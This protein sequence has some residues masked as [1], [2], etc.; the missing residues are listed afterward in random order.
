MITAGIMKHL[1]RYSNRSCAAEHFRQ[2]IYQKPV[3]TPQ[4]L[5]LTCGLCGWGCAEPLCTTCSRCVLRCSPLQPTKRPVN[6]DERSNEA[7]ASHAAYQLSKRTPSCQRHQRHLVDGNDTTVCCT[8]RKAAIDDH[9]QNTTLTVLTSVLSVSF[10][11]QCLADSVRI[12][13]SPA[14]SAKLPTLL[15]SR[16]SKDIYT[17]A[18]SSSEVHRSDSLFTT[19]RPTTQT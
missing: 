4:V 14:G 16:L 17:A 9:C 10:L 7:H 5:G 3:E 1:Y 19:S 11:C 18:P 2:C 13:E 12:V 8:S 6:A 15:L